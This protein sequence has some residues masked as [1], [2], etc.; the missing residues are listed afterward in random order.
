MFRLMA[1][2]LSLNK[3]Y[4]D[5]FA[6][7]P[8]GICLCRS[9]HYPPTPPDAAGR[10]RGVGAHTD[11]GA[12]T[13]LL[14]DK[15]GGLE[16]L[17]KPT[18]SWHAVTPIEGAYVCNIG[19]LMRMCLSHSFVIGQLL[20]MCSER[21]SND[22]YKSTMHRVIS[23]LSQTD[24]YSCAFFNDGALDMII[25]ALPGTV[26]EGESPIY[27]PL[28]VEKHI[29]ERYIQSYGAGGTVIEE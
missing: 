10:T 9:H 13:L 22:Q 6:D 4:F 5:E 1:L 17:H 3:S 11:F 27:P 25:Q 21:W 8:N 28:Q 2:S 23:P 7:D 24:R 29:A 18:G 20:M 12:L 14:Q 19:D 15:V 16:V 26:K